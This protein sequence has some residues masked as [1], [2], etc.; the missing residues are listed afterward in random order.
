MTKYERFGNTD[1]RV[2]HF[3]KFGKI[4]YGSVIGNKENFLKNFSQNFVKIALCGVVG[5]ERNFRGFGILP[6]KPNLSGKP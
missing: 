6:N 5:S 1:C 3:R 4:G 2:F